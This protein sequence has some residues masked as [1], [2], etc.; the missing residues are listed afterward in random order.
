MILILIFFIC[1]NGRY[2]SLLNIY[3]YQKSSVI[4]F[5]VAIHTGEM[6]YKCSKCECSFFKDKELKLHMK[7][8]AKDQFLQHLR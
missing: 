6:P 2:L 1:R 8:H 5:L 4:S 3:K 7:L